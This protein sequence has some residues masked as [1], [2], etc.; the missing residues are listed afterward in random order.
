MGKLLLAIII[1]ATV[2]TALVRP[3]VGITSYYL[4]SILGPQYIWWWNFE[5]LRVSFMVAIFTF[6]G[7]AF[8]VLKKNYDFSFLLNRQ[9]FWLALLWFCVALSYFFGPYVDSF[10]SSGLNPKQLLSLTNTIFLFYFCASLEM[11]ELRKLR[12]L[13]IIF[14]ASTIYLA[15]W[16][17]N[18]Y[19]TQN[20]NQFNMGRLM[21]PSSV[22]GGSVYN[23]ENTF[24]MLFVT[25][26]PFIYSLGLELQ[27]KWLRYLLWS[28]I[29]LAWH[30]IFLTGS[31]GGLLGLGVTVLLTV[32]LSGRKFLALPLIVL[33]IVFYQWQAGDVMKQRSDTIVDYEGESSAESRIIAWKG[34]LGMMTAHP[35][36]GVGLGSFVTALP[37]FIESK[38][39]VAHNT[40]IQFTAES[41]LGAGVAYLAIVTIFFLNSCKISARSRENENSQ[42]IILI[43]RYN[44]ASSISFA[45]LIV[46]S[47]FLSLNNYEIFFFLLIFNNALLQICQRTT[48][49]ENQH[50]LALV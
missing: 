28:I 36:V 45:G 41:G 26:V 34:G 47:M 35:F 14:V 9:N 44:N 30:A 10:N 42:N 7:V 50:L 46:C 32:L 21:G 3:W 48:A 38:P 2:A 27:R 24:A 33:F 19:F 16:A 5:G 11:N 13:M 43:E 22:D 31:R 12:Y 1:F 17:N 20:W 15:Y 29:P 25:G 23:D 6:A 4:L 49:T 37:R 40:F 39:R 18:Q 8:Q